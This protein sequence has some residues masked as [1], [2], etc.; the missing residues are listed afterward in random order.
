VKDEREI[1]HAN[2]S[3]RRDA[4]RKVTY[5]PSAK[6]KKLPTGGLV[7]FHGTSLQKP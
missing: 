1:L 5:K 7:G 3:H 6:Q 2:N 4:S